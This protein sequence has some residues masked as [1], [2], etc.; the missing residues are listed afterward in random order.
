MGTFL[1]YF[2]SFVIT[3]KVLESS[4]GYFLFKNFNF[5]SSD[6]FSTHNFTNLFKKLFGKPFLWFPV[7]EYFK[8][9]MGLNYEFL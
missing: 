9:T 3:Y 1:F 5:K 6:T 4:F 2:N 8:T 7:D